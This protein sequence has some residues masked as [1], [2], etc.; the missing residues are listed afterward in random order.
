V[1]EVR[2]VVHGWTARIEGKLSRDSRG[3]IDGLADRGIVEAQHASSLEANLARTPSIAPA[4][5]VTPN[6]I[7]KGQRTSEDV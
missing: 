2:E 6:T 4:G 5:W 3:E 1:T 7:S